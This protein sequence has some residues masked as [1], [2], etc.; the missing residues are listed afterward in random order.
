MKVFLCI[1][2]NIFEAWSRVLRSGF[3]CD[4]IFVVT[5][6]HFLIVPLRLS[7]DKLSQLIVAAWLEILDV[8]S[9]VN[10]PNSAI[11]ISQAGD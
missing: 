1:F 4:F 10:R 9:A 7:I 5:C 8:L 3:F 11:E 6:P 2:N